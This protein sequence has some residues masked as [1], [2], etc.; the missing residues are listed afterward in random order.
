MIFLFRFDIKG[1][2]GID[3]ILNE[4]IAND[5]YLDCNKRLKPLVK[6]SGETLLRYRNLSVDKTIMYGNLLDSGQFEVMLSTGLGA[7]FNIEEKNNLFLDA[8]KIADIL[9]EV[10]DRRIMEEKNGIINSN[11]ENIFPSN[12]NN[13]DQD[14]EAMGELKSLEDKLGKFQSMPLRPNIKKLNIDDFPSGVE[15]TRDYDHRGHAFKFKHKT[16]GD[17]GRIVLVS[18]GGIK[19]CLQPELNIDNQN[20]SEHDIKQKNEMF[21]SVIDVV[22]KCFEENFSK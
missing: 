5:M 22:F 18:V 20:L 2:N 12:L 21:Q 4:D 8:K 10:M 9:C 3:F 15:M 17:L 14:I 13:L 11:K 16:F 19:T 1:E 7:H 6:V